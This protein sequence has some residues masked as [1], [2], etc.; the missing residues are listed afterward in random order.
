MEGSEITKSM[1]FCAVFPTL[2]F[3]FATFPNLVSE[4]SLLFPNLVSELRLL[5]PNFFTEDFCESPKVF[6]ELSSFTGYFLRGTV[7]PVG[8]FFYGD[9]AVLAPI[10]VIE[11]G[12]ERGGFGLVTRLLAGQEVGQLLGQFTHL[13]ETGTT[14][15]HV[16][17]LGKHVGNDGV[18]AYGRHIVDVA[19]LNLCAVEHRTGRHQLHT[20]IV[21]IN[22]YF[23]AHHRIIPMD[24][25]VD[26]SFKDSPVGIVGQIKAVVGHL[27]P[28]AHGVVLDEVHAVL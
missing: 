20:V 19:V 7:Y 2:L 25:V 17:E 21:N 16:V 22:M 1:I 8:H 11:S 14:F 23:A 9:S 15:L 26:Q 5:S 18:A 27:D 28:A 3:L 12:E 13:A 10:Q 24:K 6:S 4:L